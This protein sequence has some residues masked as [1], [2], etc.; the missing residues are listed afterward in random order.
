MLL[1]VV[2]SFNDVADVIAIIVADVIATL[3]FI[4][5]WLML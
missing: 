4:L 3:F 5:Y 2:Y 1:P